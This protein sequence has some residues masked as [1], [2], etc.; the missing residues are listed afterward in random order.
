MS[1]RNGNAGRFFIH[2]SGDNRVLS[3][4]CRPTSRGKLSKTHFSDVTRHEKTLVWIAI[5]GII[6][7]EYVLHSCVSRLVSLISSPL[8]FLLDNCGDY[9]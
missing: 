3:C 5:R 7:T 4:N 1:L 6:W 2:C 9:A 8:S